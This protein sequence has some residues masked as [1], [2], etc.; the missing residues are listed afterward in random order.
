MRTHLKKRRGQNTVEYFILAVLLAV[1]TIRAFKLLGGAVKTQVQNVS[2][3]ITGGSEFDTNSED[4][5]S[6]LTIDEESLK[7]SSS[8]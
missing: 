4:N 6:S 8:Q 3:A 7:P 5:A 2:T 1:G